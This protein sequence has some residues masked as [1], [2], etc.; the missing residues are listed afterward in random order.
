VFEGE[1]KGLVIAEIEL[2]SEDQ[3]IALP[4]WVKADVTHDPRYYNANLVAMPYS[5]W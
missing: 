1:N 3:E 2:K 5:R 4:P